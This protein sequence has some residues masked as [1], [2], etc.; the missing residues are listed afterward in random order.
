MMS[1]CCATGTVGPRKDATHAAVLRLRGFGVAH[2]RKVVLAEVDLTLS[3]TGVLVLLGPC[4]TGKSTLLRA[5]SGALAE[6]STSRVWGDAEYIGRAIGLDG[7]WPA[8]VGQSARSMMSS[9]FEN[10]VCNLPDRERLTRAQQRSLVCRRL[11]EN[12]LDALIPLLE[13]PVETLSPA[14]Q[15]HVAI[16][17]AVAADPE[18]LCV[19]EPTANLADPDAERLIA[20]LCRESLRRALIVATHHQGHARLLGGRTALLAGGRIQEIAET[21]DFFAAPQTRAGREFVRGGT[22]LLPS[23]DAMPQ[24]LDDGVPPPPPLPLVARIAI[25]GSRGPRGFHWLRP[26]ELAG[27]PKPGVV[28]DLDY[29][30]AALRCVGIR[31]LVNLTEHAMDP[32]HLARFGIE[33]HAF[34]IADMAPPSTAQTVGIC[35]LIDRAIAAREPLAVHCRAGLGRTGTVLALYLVWRG[36]AGAAALETVR[37][38]EPQWVQ[39]ARQVAAIDAFPAWCARARATVEPE[40]RSEASNAADAQDFFCQPTINTH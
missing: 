21:A 13:Q 14:L 15:R 24:D 25:N 7:R 31:H 37:R 20:H 33:A 22:C 2:A 26:G 30:L 35:T 4:G 28:G 34:P 1:S 3:S 38:I 17:R 39:S 36:A 5:L 9:V 23:P 40:R 27:T 19:D 8:L 12:A 6:T 18:L 10:L 29:D 16:V 11:R 32:V